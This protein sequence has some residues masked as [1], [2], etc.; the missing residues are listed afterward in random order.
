MNSATEYFIWLSEI[1]GAGTTLSKRIFEAFSGDMR[2]AYEAT[3]NEYLSKGFTNEESVLLSDKD[4]TRANMILDYCAENKVGLLPM[5]SEYYPSRLYDIPNPPAVLYYKGRIEKLCGGA[6]ITAVGSRQCSEPAYTAGYEL[7]HKL[8]CCGVSLVSGLAEGI[9]TAC[10]SGALDGNGFVIGVLGSGINIL[11]PFNNNDLFSRIFRT[12]LVITEFSPFTEP[13]R[14]NFPIR[15]RIMAALGDAVLVVEAA[16]NSGAL[17]T[18][19]QAAGMGR[20]IFAVPGSITDAHCYGSNA[21]IKNGASAVTCAED[22]IDELSFA[23]PAT[24]GVS[25]EKKLSRLDKYLSRRKR[26][27]ERR[28]GI[29]K[30]KS[31]ENGTLKKQV[32]PAEPENAEENAPSPMPDISA[33]S[34]TESRIYLFLREG[35]ATADIICAKLSLEQNKVLAELT[36]LEIYGLIESL[37][38]GVYSAL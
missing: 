21:L 1:A 26:R 33:L 5:G 19:E 36:M 29:Q 15:N 13:L 6:I 3:E 30:E 12:G 23:Y 22:V 4:F 37:P 2:A 14:V 35:K 24:V 38:G 10:I 16:K 27:E 17:I 28:H 34:E 31:S 9:D 32:L 8:A 25:A 18:A 20:R 7:C 11:Y